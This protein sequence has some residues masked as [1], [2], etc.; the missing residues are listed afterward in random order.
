MDIITHFPMTETNVFIKTGDVIAFDFNREMHY[1]SKVNTTNQL[2]IT[3]K[4]HYCIYPKHMVWFGKQMCAL[5]VYYDRLFR[6][7]FLHT[8]TPVTNREKIGAA[9]VM[10]GT[11]SYAWIE[12]WIGYKNI[13]FFGFFLWIIWGNI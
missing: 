6:D 5:N 11:N 4:A 10:L 9:L 1:I 3:M 12:M 2:R 8:I 13:L 7:L